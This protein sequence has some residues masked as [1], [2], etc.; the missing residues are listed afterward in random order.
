MKTQRVIVVG[1]DSLL[2]AGLESLLSHQ[3]NL[4]V[5]GFSISHVGS[6]LKYIWHI[7]PDV[8]VLSTNSG[9]EP[10][11]LL[12]NLEGY[13]NIRIIEVDDKQNVLQ[14]FD[15]HQTLTTSQTDLMAIVNS[16]HGF[17]SGARKRL[18]VC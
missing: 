15:K 10:T 16:N 6:L 18:P 3:L 1:G 5:V 14:V 13:P 8:I 17:L 12:K 2:H 11:L 7:L 9:I 4:S